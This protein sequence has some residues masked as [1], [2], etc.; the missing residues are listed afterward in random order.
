MTKQAS[1]L[2]ELTSRQ[3]DA[4]RW[5]MAGARSEQELGKGTENLDLADT[6]FRRATE[7]LW[8]ILDLLEMASDPQA[9]VL[10]AA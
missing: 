1:P 7:H 8:V 4:L 5:H 9:S 3:W 6:H 2:P 10:D